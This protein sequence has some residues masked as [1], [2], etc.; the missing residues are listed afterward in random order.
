MRPS[1]IGVR[2]PLILTTPGTGFPVVMRDSSG[3]V[4]RDRGKPGLARRTAVV[5][6]FWRY[7]EAGPSA[8]ADQSEYSSER[9]FFAV[10]THI[11]KANRWRIHP[12][13]AADSRPYRN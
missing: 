13:K 2:T 3:V 11:G 1:A 9:N 12:E 6:P 7:A 5:C 8:A 4:R 10:W